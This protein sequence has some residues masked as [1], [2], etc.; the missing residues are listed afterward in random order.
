MQIS[1]CV[2]HILSETSEEFKE[3][4]LWPNERTQTLSLLVT[5]SAGGNENQ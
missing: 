1:F 3:G 4:N 5:K 2:E